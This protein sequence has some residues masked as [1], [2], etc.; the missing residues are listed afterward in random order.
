[1]HPQGKSEGS[2]NFLTMQVHTS[3]IS[4]HLIIFLLAYHRGEGSGCTTGIMP[5][6]VTC[7]FSFLGCLMLYL[8]LPGWL[9]FWRFLK[10]TILPILPCIALPPDWVE[11]VTQDADTLSYYWCSVRLPHLPQKLIQCWMFKLEFEF[12]QTV[13]G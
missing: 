4:S 13:R 1:M 7:H 12:D 5:C 8:F 3:I 2:Q 9:S 11:V 6:R 10:S